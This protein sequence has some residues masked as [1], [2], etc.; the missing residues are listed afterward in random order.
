M[1]KYEYRVKTEQMLDHL[2]KKEYQQAKEI[3]D[4][5]D[6]RRV[7][8]AS[9][10]N[11]VSEIYEYNGEF[12]KGRDILFLAFDRAPGSRKIVYRLGTLALKIKDIREATDSYEEFVKLAPKDPNQYILKYKILR[13]QGAS[14]TDQ[15]TALEEF[16]KA[17]Y[18]EKWAYELA[19]LYDEAGMTAECLEECDD[20]IL[21]FSEGKYVYK[22]MELKMQYKP[23]TPSQQEKY[24]RRFEKNGGETEEIPDLETYVAENEEPEDHLDEAATEHS[25]AVSE[26][27]VEDIPESIGQQDTGKEESSEKPVR[28]PEKKKIGDTMRLD[29]ALEQL[30]HRKPEVSAAEDEEPDISDLESAIGD[31]ESVVDLDMVNQI[32]QEKHTGDVPIGMK[33]LI[34]GEV[35]EEAADKTERI[36][37]EITTDITEDDAEELDLEDL[38]AEELPEEVEEA[39]P[40]EEEAEEVEETEPVEEEAEEIEEAEQVTIFLILRGYL[41]ILPQKDTMLKIN[42]IIVIRGENP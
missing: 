7:K 11:T 26:E 22:A 36:P 41:S 8:N 18:I 1:D 5:I 38:V 21:W 35:S 34:P 39:E 42:D 10:L 12:K 3:A 28:K 29:E 32:S 16:K 31:I 20:L 17:E 4:G 25:E 23:L 9:M 24:N 14:L 19:K 15:I 6:W 27:P 40:V 13:T 30:L 2:E 33:E 37:V